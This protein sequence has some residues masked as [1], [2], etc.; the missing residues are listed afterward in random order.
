MRAH[1]IMTTKVHT[2]KRDTSVGEIAY[3]MTTERIGGVPIVD[4]NGEVVGMVS[5]T[6]LMHRAETGTERKRKW[7]IS[8][9]IDDDMRARDFI[10]A[11]GQKAEHVMSP[12]VPSSPRSPISLKPTISSA[13]RY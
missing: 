3:L 4:D 7:W 9:F 11:H 8:L 5:E 1:Q 13:S 10:K 12:T 2:A 6:D